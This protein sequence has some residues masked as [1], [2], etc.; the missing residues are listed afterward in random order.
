M[1]RTRH[2]LLLVFVG[3]IAFPL[4]PLF[5]TD[6]SSLNFIVRDPVTNAG[7][8]FGTSS[9]FQLFGSFGQTAIGKSSTSS[10]SVQSGF[11]Y[12]PAP[13]PP[14]P[15][16]PSP[17]PTPSSGGGG[18]GGPAIPYAPTQ[19]TI[20][21]RAYPKSSI[22][23]TID[24]KIIGTLQAD[25]TAFFSGTFDTSPGFHGFGV[26][27]TDSK[28]RR[29]L[30]YTFSLVVPAQGIS[31]ISGVYIAPTIEVE[32]SEVRRGDIVNIFGQTIP[33]STVSLFINSEEEITETLTTGND[34]VYLLP[35]DSGR[36]AYGEHTVKS[37]AENDNIMSAASQLVSFRV[38]TKN[39]LRQLPGDLNLNGQ[40][41]IV[42]FSVL[43]FWWNNSSAKALN[44]TDV[45]KDG[46]VGLAD[47][48]ILL[49]YWTG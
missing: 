9:S 6:F 47:L 30:T 24:S 13:A 29:S 41:N 2:I 11:L 19:V 37:Q 27:A 5:A 21:G 8:G 31:T 12:F 25:G 36:L 44:A 35:F 45:N 10:F 28:G 26:Y 16:P 46:R 33:S 1:I 43:L 15:P 14:P 32:K 17:S 42:D 4:A 23:V 22:T 48:S 18:G 40:V 20:S 34:G 7:A 38:G 3:T 39:I 49:Y